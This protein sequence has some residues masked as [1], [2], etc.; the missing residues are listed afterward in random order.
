MNPAAD[1]AS[2]C[3]RITT[4]VGA[5]SGDVVFA[6]NLPVFSGHFPGSPLVPGVHQLA[7]VAEV[8]ARCGVAGTITRIDRCKW[9]AMVRPGD[10]LRV[11]ITW[12]AA[13]EGGTI[14]DGT[15]TVAGPAGPQVA[16]SC[17]L[18]LG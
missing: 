9:T 8:A 14:V 11:A 10:A 12:K 5:G 7:A 2:A 4:G 16:C 17:R 6:P 1:A 18:V 3:Q 15:C 13:P